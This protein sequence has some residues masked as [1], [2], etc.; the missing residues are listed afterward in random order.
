MHAMCTWEEGCWPYFIHL[1]PTPK[2]FLPWFVFSSSLK[3]YIHILGGKSSWECHFCAQVK[4]MFCSWCTF[5]LPCFIGIYFCTVYILIFGSVE[6]VK[7][8]VT[9]RFGNLLDL[10]ML[11]VDAE[12]YWLFFVAIMWS[13]S[14]MCTS[15]ICRRT[16]QNV[17]CFLPL[18][19]QVF[20]LVVIEG[21]RRS[22][23]CG[24]DR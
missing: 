12:K 22:P 23:Q 7:S 11:N 13:R 18:L 3:W 20:N 5:S 4:R 14:A 19:R 10:G 6:S 21:K 16:S 8:L 24:K 17:M 1:P 2:Q 9:R 15:Q